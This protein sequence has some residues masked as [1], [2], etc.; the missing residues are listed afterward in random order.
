MKRLTT[1]EFVTRA[2]GVHGDAYDYSQTEYVKA[3]EPV[4]IVCPVHGPF[5][6]RPNKHLSGQGCPECS[7][8]TRSR[9]QAMGAEEFVTRARAVHGDAYDYSHVDYRNN[10]TKVEIICP[11]HGPFMQTPGKHLQGNGCPSCGHS[12]SA[13]DPTGAIA[14]KRRATM[15]E[16]YGTDNPMRVQ[17]MKAAQAATC[18]GRYGR[19]QKVVPVTVPQC[20]VVETA[21][22]DNRQLQAGLP[23][24]SFTGSARNVT[25][26]VRWFQF[27]VVYA[28]ELAM[29]SEN[30]TNQAGVSLHS[31]L[32]ANREKYLGKSPDELTDMEI[33]RG[34]TIAGFVRGYT[35]FDNTLMC[36]V[37][38]ECSIKSVYDPCAGWGERMLT[39][40]AHGVEYM[41]VDV[42]EALAPGYAAMIEDMGLQNCSFTV[43]DAAIVAP[44]KVDAVITCPPYGSTEIYSEDGA[45]NLSDEDFIR[46]WRQVVGRVSGRGIEWFCFQINQRW[47]ELMSEQV[48]DFGYQLMKRYDAPVK[49]SH[50]NRRGGASTKREFESMLVFHKD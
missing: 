19:A 15:L 42:N 20:V 23:P 3:S 14:E 27:P 34:L 21:Q 29:W 38:D 37:L 7:R 11:V 50:F 4:T 5:L 47:L 45:E 13:L 46:W 39:C 43:G 40:A 25:A 31:R 18:V 48:E 10:R 22:D 44:A 6:Q 9:G 32:Y 35:V 33:I 36:K 17:S 41:G 2:Q 26:W 24:R 8:A 30:K 16:R 12:R 1:E 28:R 49:S